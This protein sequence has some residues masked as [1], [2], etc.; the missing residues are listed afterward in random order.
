MRKLSSRICD[1][2]FIGFACNSSCYG[3][4]VIKIDVLDYNIINES[5]NAIFFKHM[6]PLKNKEKL[7]HESFVA[8]NKFADEVQEL[9]RSKRARKKK[10]ILV[11]LLLILLMMI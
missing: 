10:G 1:Y 5:E 7:L 6:F 11:I 8:S 3:F 4:L 9:R 2:D